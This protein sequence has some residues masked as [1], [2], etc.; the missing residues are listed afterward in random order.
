MSTAAADIRWRGMVAATVSITVVGI[1]IGLAIPLL[2]TILE[3]RGYSATLIGLNSAAAGVA[4]MAAAPLATPLAVRFGVVPVLVTMIVATAVSFCG[5]YF[6]QSYWM[7]F[8]LRIVFHAAINIIFI[9]SEFWISD[10][11]PERRRGFILGLYATMLSGGFA[12]GPWL[13]AQ[14]GSDGFAPFAAGSAIILASLVPILLAAGH[15]PSLHETGNRG[16]IIRYSLLVP[17][18]TAAVLIFG[19]V[20]TGGFA[21]FP[22]YGMRIGF[23][24][25]DAALLISMIGLGN[26]AMQLPL[27]M[28]SDRVSDRRILLA[29]LTALGF[30]GVLLLPAI[31]QN[32]T[33]VAL[34]MFLWGG[35]VGGLYVV[36]LAHLASKL[37]GRDLAAAN[38]A[39]VFCYSIGMLVG[40]QAIGIGM[41]IAGPPGFAWTIASFFLAYTLFA[42]HRI[43]QR[44]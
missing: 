2:S 26:M 18:A 38:S 15:E 13:F 29:A 41:D 4:S 3:I 30:A 14:L 43:I 1:A 21:L 32:W 25:S 19:A 7:W 28:F 39:F 33:L 42:V 11:A 27:G 16:G 12:A 36:G 31:G 23:S 5:F 35:A 34:L 8:P 20:E 9:L 10:S 6:S 22:V 44:T 37:S 17:T 40:P 24:E